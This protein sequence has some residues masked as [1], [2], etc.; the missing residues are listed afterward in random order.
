MRATNSPGTPCD[1]EPIGHCRDARSGAFA[2]GLGAGT[3]LGLG[4]GAVPVC[5]AA[6]PG[7]GHQFAFV[8]SGS[9]RAPAPGAHHPD[10]CAF[11]A[12]LAGPGL[13]VARVAGQGARA[14]A[15]D[16]RRAGVGG[17]R[18]C[19]YF[20]AAFCGSGRWLDGAHTAVAAPLH[21]HL[22]P[23]VQQSHQRLDFG[24]P[25][26]LWVR[27]FVRPA[28][29]RQDHRGRAARRRPAVPAARHEFWGGRLAVC[30]VLRHT[31]RHGAFALALCAAGARQG[32]AGGEPPDT[33]GLRRAG[34]ARL[35]RLSFR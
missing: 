23:P 25:P 26:A 18:A 34:D 11:C 2:T 5:T 15:S 31:C 28:R 24:G 6:A 7:G 12:G 9:D 22:F 29:W 1:V 27:A 21:H 30:A 33:A 8:F 4:L 10:L 13:A 20:R 16:G 3:G 32:G 14:P 35:A 19:R 17:P